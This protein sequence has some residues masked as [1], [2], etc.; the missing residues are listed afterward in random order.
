MILYGSSLAVQWL[1]LHTSTAEGTGSI[2]GQ[3]TRIPHA[4]WLGKKKFFLMLL[5]LFNFFIVVKYTNV[6]YNVIIFT[7]YTILA[8]YN[9]TIQW[10]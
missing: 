7:T 5:Y 3:E 9:Y 8:I 6:F 10:Q 1:R 4:S 2:P